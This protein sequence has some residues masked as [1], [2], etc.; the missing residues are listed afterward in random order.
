MYQELQLF[1]ET[2]DGYPVWGTEGNDLPLPALRVGDLF[3]HESLPAMNW[4]T[5][6]KPSQA[7]KVIAIKHVFRET[8][9]GPEAD[10]LLKVAVAL[11]DLESRQEAALNEAETDLENQTRRGD[12]LS[13]LLCDL[14]KY[15]APE[16]RNK[17]VQGIVSTMK[18]MA[19]HGIEDEAGNSWEEAAMILQADGHVLAEMLRGEIQADVRRAIA[20]LDSEDRLTLWLA[21]AGLDDWYPDD[22][23]DAQSRF[24]PLTHSRRA[25]DT[26][27]EQLTEYV[28]SLLYAHD[29]PV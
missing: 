23:P 17:L 8:G 4:R 19:A 16:V 21:A 26:A 12:F 13:V 11:D 5:P 2:F 6:P 24:D 3:E 29:L 10:H 7:F 1:E 18:D 9:R 20:Q 25:L 28:L 27:E 15:K 22:F 14:A